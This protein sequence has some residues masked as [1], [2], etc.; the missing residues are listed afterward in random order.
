MTGRRLVLYVAHGTDCFVQEAAFSILSLWRQSGGDHYPVVVVTDRRELFEQLL[1]PNDKLRFLALTPQQRDLWRGPN[2]YIHRIKPLAIQWAA[3]QIKAQ[4]KDSLLYVDSDTVFTT[5]PSAL[6]DWA[7]EGGVVLN[8]C[9]GQVRSL[10]TNTRS[11][12][13]LHDALQSHS[14]NVGGATMQVPMD[15]QLWNSGVLAFR[16]D[17]LPVF[18]DVVDLIDQM[19]PVVNVHT[20]EQVALSVLLQARGI[21]L[22]EC[23]R[24]VF[25]YHVFKEFR[26]DLERFFERYGALP[27][28]ERLAHWPEIDPVLRI[29]P[30]LQF[31]ALPKWRRQWL[32]LIGR[33]WQA[34]PYPWVMP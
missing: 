19:F 11:H 28:S 14:F 10:R 17:L 9:E 33:P 20:V 18:D 6:F 32:K 22:K 24:D 29:Q 26:L 7:S 3:R 21:E 8:E 31:N 30:K 4:D 27:V 13:R 16:A 2:H 5:S 15:T 1:G 23:L 34:L 12:R 25:H